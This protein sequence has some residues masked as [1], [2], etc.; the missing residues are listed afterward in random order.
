MATHGIHERNKIFMPL[1]YSNCIRISTCVCLCYCVTCY[2]ISGGG[3][4]DKVYKSFWALKS[5]TY[6]EDSR[7]DNTLSFKTRLFPQH[8][9]HWGD[10]IWMDCCQLKVSQLLWPICVWMHKFYWA[11]FV[12]RPRKKPQGA[13]LSNKHFHPPN[14]ITDCNVYTAT[15]AVVAV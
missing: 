12:C 13:F 5:S 15:P 1:Y 6:F 7:T 2:V 9:E 10:E 11:E 4:S 14:L 3:R 8:C